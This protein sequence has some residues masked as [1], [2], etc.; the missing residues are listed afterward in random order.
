MRDEGAAVVC[1]TIPPHRIVVPVEYVRR[2]GEAGEADGRPMDLATLL[3]TTVP[4]ERRRLLRIALGGAG[5]WVLVGQDV[6]VIRIPHASFAELPRWLH[7]LAA[8][9]PLAGVV[10]IDGRLGFELDV[11]RLLPESVS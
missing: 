3:E 6:K 4:E 5:L 11:A 1:A 7:G 10:D 8:R 9:L 2:I